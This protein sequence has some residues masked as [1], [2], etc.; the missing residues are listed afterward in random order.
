MNKE[1]FGKTLAECQGYQFSA[2]KANVND[3]KYN[4]LASKVEVGQY[5]DVKCT[6]REM[7]DEETGNTWPL[8][9]S[10]SSYVTL[11][12]LMAMSS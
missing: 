8:L 6:I 4:N 5:V 10:N 1:L 3:N 12:Q 2:V 9:T 7:V 11:E